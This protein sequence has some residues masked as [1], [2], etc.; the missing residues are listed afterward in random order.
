MTE[1]FFPQKPYANP[2]IYAY[3]DTNPEYNG[4]LKIGF[5]NR[6]VL[7]R[8]KEQYPTIR[9]GKLPYKI[10]LDE[11]AMRKDG[12]T[13]YDFDVFKYLKKRKVKNPAGEWFKCD[14]KKVKATIIA[15]KKQ[16]RK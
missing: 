13:F 8:V 3:K 5:T 4:L 14:V 15:L 1:D 16:R 10:I 2:R 12:T 11:S 9:P 6:S 7:E